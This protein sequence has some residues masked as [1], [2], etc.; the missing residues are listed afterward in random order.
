[1]RYSSECHGITITQRRKNVVSRRAFESKSCRGKAFQKIRRILT[2]L[3]PFAFAFAFGAFKS[4]S[5]NFGLFRT[6]SE[7]QNFRLGHGKS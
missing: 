7:F 2:D 5:K 3:L 1:M 6:D 4:W